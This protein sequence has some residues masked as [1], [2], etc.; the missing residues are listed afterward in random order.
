MKPATWI[1]KR[2][3]INHLEPITRYSGVGYGA[4]DET[5]RKILEILAISGYSYYEQEIK[6]FLINALSPDP[7]KRRALLKGARNL[8]ILQTNQLVELAQIKIDAYK[9]AAEVDRLNHKLNLLIALL[10]RRD[11]WLSLKNLYFIFGCSHMGLKPHIKEFQEAYGLEVDDSCVIHYYKMPGR[12][13][14]MCR[15][16]VSVLS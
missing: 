10:I 13:T 3:V 11:E 8:T 9:A 2:A 12:Y 5:D 4:L 6:N 14:D 7:A 16:Q 15:E 1:K